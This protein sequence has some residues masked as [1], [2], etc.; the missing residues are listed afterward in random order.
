MT[1][2]D[3]IDRALDAAL[4]MTFP[5]SDPIAVCAYEPR[6]R[7]A[8]SSADKTRER[9]SARSQRVKDELVAAIC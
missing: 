6:S 9:T 4:E 8:E 5:A 7:S 1:R 3:R 2:E